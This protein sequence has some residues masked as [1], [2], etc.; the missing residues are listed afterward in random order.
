MAIARCIATI[1]YFTG[2]PE[3]VISNVFYWASVTPLDT[4]QA[5]GIVTRLNAFYNAID[6]HLSPVLVP[7]SLRY[8]FYHMEDPEPRVPFYDVPGAGLTLGSAGTAEESSVCL[9][10]QAAPASG[11]PQARRRGRIYIGP[12]ASTA[13]TNGTSSAFSQISGTVRADLA[14]AAAILADQSEPHQWAVYSTVDNVARQIVGG[15]IDNAVDT[16]RR[17]GRRA[18]IRNNWIGQA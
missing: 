11:D 14:A 5:A 16:Q 6:A 17:R 8:R 7:S 4:D 13:I 9:S 10:Y 12:L 15:W 1:N 3:D 18:T 2:L